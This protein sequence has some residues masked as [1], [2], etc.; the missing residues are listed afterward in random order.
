MAQFPLIGE[1]LSLLTAVLWSLGVVLFKKA[2]ETVHPLAL[3]LYKNTLAVLLFL[4]TLPL[5]G[6]P[7]FAA[8]PGQEYAIVLLSGV[9][10]IGIADT[11][12]FR[13]LNILGAGRAAIIDTL[14]SPSV[15]ALSYLFLGERLTVPQLLGAGLV[16][17]GVLVASWVREKVEVPRRMI[18][19][20]SA[21]GALAVVLM[22][23]SLVIVKPVLARMPVLWVTQWRLIGGALVLMLILLPR[24]DRS[25]LLRPL[26]FGAGVPYTLF[27]SIV[28]AYLVMMTWLGGMKYTTASLASALN[29]TA[30]VITFL[31]AALFLRERVTRRKL[32]ALIVS[33]VGVALLLLGQAT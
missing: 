20:G 14:F 5:L 4:P 17:A 27:G 6:V 10:G 33:I 9:L 26:V 3:N 24:R 7:L 23:A 12:F 11:L 18:Y 2:G 16:I 15:I 8:A 25:A 32:V 1:S 29:Q 28:G 19:F 22:A 21:I 13:A 30:T 31:F